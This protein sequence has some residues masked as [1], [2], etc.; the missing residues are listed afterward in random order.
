MTTTHL[1]EGRQVDRLMSPSLC[2]PPCDNMGGFNVETHHPPE[3]PSYSPGQAFICF[4]V[5]PRFILEV[6]DIASSGLE[7][8]PE[9]HSA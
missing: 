3:K 5:V 8:D 9:I 2:I 4:R 7:I 6:T 1:P